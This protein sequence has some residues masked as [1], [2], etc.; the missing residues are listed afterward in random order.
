V[1][2]AARQGLHRVGL[3]VIVAVLLVGVLDLAQRLLHQGLVVTLG[4]QEGEEAVLLQPV[5]RGALDLDL[6]AAPR[7][8]G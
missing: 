8:T 1:E 2:D 7:S 4:S 6:Q 5:E 3:D